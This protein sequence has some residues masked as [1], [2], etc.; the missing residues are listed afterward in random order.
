M[1]TDSEIKKDAED[2]L[3]W[4][5]TSM[6]PTLQSRPQ[7]GGHAHRIRTQLYAEDAGERDVKRV[8]EH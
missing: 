7:W 3:R 2:E 8:E 1:R 5:L 6:P 4:I